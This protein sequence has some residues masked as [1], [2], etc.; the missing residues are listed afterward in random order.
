MNIKPVLFI[1]G[2]KQVQDRMNQ[3]NYFCNIMNKMLLECARVENG[4]RE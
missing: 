2:E 1:D 4:M 3:N